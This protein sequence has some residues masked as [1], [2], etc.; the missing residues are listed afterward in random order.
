[1]KVAEL[2]NPPSDNED[3]EGENDLI[4]KTRGKIKQPHS[5]A[6]ESTYLT[7]RDG[8]PPTAV[9]SELLK[10]YPSIPSMIYLRSWF[11]NRH[12][13]YKRYV[14]LKRESIIAMLITHCN[15][16]LDINGLEVNLQDPFQSNQIEDVCSVLL[17]I[18]NTLAHYLILVNKLND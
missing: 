14:N 6:L 10:Q 13:K 3:D 8:N 1:M 18:Q 9:L 11:S 16:I 5:S 4:S 15:D 7:L 12:N 17:Q 2:L